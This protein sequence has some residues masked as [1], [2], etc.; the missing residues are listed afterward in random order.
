MSP[1]DYSMPSGADRRP[2]AEGVTD[3]VE[4]AGG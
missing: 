3:P 1:Y 4:G 2:A